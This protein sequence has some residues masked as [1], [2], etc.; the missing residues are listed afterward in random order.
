MTLTIGSFAP[1][2]SCSA[3]HISDVGFHVIRDRPSAARPVLMSFQPSHEMHSSLFSFQL[4]EH[5]RRF[6][7]AG[8]RGRFRTIFQ[9]DRVERCVLTLFIV[10]PSEIRLIS[11]NLSFL[12]D[13]ICQNDRCQLSFLQLT[14]VILYISQTV[15]YQEI[16]KIDINITFTTFSKNYSPDHEIFLVILR[17]IYFCFVTIVIML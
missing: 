16:L 2:L 11:Q 15:L 14:S 6:R 9:T 12:T 17:L 10:S 1:N 3:A 5:E 8:L 13:D 7:V 4:P